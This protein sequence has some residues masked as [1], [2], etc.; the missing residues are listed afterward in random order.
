M[1]LIVIYIRTKLWD[2]ATG[3]ELQRENEDDAVAMLQQNYFIRLFKFVAQLLF[4]LALM[5][6]GIF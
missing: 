3:L 5:L 6:Y 1:N 2:T 4:A